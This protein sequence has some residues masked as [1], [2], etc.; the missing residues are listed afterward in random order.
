M[1][2]WNVVAKKGQEIGVELLNSV[3]EKIDPKVLREMMGESMESE[4]KALQ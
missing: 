1:L 4:A 2:E 3:K